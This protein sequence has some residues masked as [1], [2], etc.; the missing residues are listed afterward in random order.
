MYIVLM[1]KQFHVDMIFS[2]LGPT[3]HLGDILL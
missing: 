3:S 2:I 1:S